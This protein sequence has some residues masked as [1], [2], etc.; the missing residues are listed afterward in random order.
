MVKRIDTIPDLVGALGGPSAVGELFGINPSAVGN[1]VERDV[2]PP[3]WHL[4]LLVE[5]RQRQLRV[6]PTVFGLSAEQA[7]ILLRPERPSARV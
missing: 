2:I 3:G 5:I 6:D 1:W 4:R 7:A